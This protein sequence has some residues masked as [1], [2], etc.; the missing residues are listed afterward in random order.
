MRSPDRIK[1][2]L[3]EIEFIWNQYPDLRLFQLLQ[4]ACPEETFNGNIFYMEDDYLYDRI[5][6]LADL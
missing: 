2:I 3:S 6:A 4:W 1:K 5:K